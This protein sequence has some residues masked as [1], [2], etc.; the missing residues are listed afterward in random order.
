MTR[1]IE[2]PIPYELLR[3][4][5]E[6]AQAAGLRREAYIRSVLS[7]EVN[8]EPSVGEILAAFRDQ[9]TDSGVSDDELDSIFSQAREEA[10]RERRLPGAGER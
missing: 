9:V 2:L 3:L 8:A 10:F 1:T 5:D 4:I 6:R 7:R